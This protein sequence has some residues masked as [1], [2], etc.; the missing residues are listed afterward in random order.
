MLVTP[1][2]YHQVQNRDGKLNE[3]LQ[4]KIKQKNFGVGI[5]CNS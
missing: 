5:A 3:E 1:K 2:K 4:P